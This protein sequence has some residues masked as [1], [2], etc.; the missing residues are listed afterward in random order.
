MREGRKRQI[1]R[2]A[3][4]LGHPAREL[5]RVRLGPL[6]LRSLE[7]GQWRYLTSQEIRDLESLKRRAKR[8]RKR[9]SRRRRGK[10]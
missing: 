1:R 8:R 4:L 9:G 5:K 2:V 7:A 6:Q 10:R 3:A